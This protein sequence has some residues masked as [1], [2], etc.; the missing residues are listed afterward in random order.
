MYKDP[1]LSSLA[2]RLREELASRGAQL[3]QVQALEVL[4]RLS[5]AKT[6]HVAH[7]RHNA[8]VSIEGTALAQAS[9]LMFESLGRFEGNV[10]GLLAS[11]TS[12]YALERTQGSRAVEQAVAA[13]FEHQNAP[14]VSALYQGFRL[15]ELPALFDAGVARLTDSLE[16]QVRATQRS[17]G[18]ADNLVYQGTVRDWRLSDGAVLSE[19]PEHHRQLFDLKVAQNPG[20][21]MF[22]DITPAGLLP[23]ECEGKQMMSLFI[24]INEGRPCVHMSNASSGEQVLT[25]FFTEDGLYLRP[26]NSDARILAG[27]PSAPALALLSQELEDP[28]TYR[29]TN[30]AFV[31]SR[32]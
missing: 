15:D 13:L 32:S 17:Q 4:A 1:Q 24:E 14:V 5:G 30:T 31:E 18:S 29:Q 8:A 20:Y 16:R 7:A 3:T 21:Q 22:V 6:L 25:V 11:I 19:L 12:A 2:K 10:R 27:V 26:D 23:D 9:D 28:S